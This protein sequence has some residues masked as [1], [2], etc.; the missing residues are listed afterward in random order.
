MKKII[1][2]WG[3]FALLFGYGC[4]E[5]SKVA[6]GKTLVKINNYK[7]TEG[8]LNFLTGANPRASLYLAT[9]A[10][11]QQVLDSLVEKELLYQSAIK[12]GLNKVSE[13]KAQMDYNNREILAKVRLEAAVNEEAKKYYDSHKDEFEQVKIAT[14][15]IRFK[16]KKKEEAQNVA[17]QLR[18]RLAAGEAFAVVAKETSEDALTKERGGDLGWV[19][20]NDVG[21]SRRG[22]APLVNAAFL[23]K[24]G[25]ISNP[26]AIEDG[27]F[28]LTV[29]DGPSMKPFE[30]VKGPIAFRLR[31]ETKKTLL[32]QLKEKSKIQYFENGKN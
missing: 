4:G 11:R 18:S 8:D 23:M 10:N 20:R 25:E 24:Q 16:G 31:E 26:I 22:L 9:P 29:T 21:M 6:S 12:E 13:V 14:I 30:E 5:Q 19:T 15:L 17:Q 32:Q 7:I 2:A 27:I 1:L 3:V 28:I